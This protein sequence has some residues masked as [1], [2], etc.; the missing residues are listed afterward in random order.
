MPVTRA[1][2]STSREPAIWPTYSN[3]AGTDCACTATTATSG[4]TCPCGCDA[5]CSQPLSSAET[6][7]I[8]AAAAACKEN[9][10]IFMVFSPRMYALFHHVLTDAGFGPPW[11]FLLEMS[12]VMASLLRLLIWLAKV[13]PLVGVFLLALILMLLTSLTVVGVWFALRLL[14]FCLPG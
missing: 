8:D 13:S 6:I 11:R 9:S 5:A 14:T 12:S 3:V 4:G 1:R 10:L 2:T 7:V